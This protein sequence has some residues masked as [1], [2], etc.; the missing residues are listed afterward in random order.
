MIN[1]L[2]SAHRG[3]RKRERFYEPA[4]F[5]YNFGQNEIEKFDVP[6][7]FNRNE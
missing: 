3:E 2:K 1:R 7:I 6:E 4:V 5:E